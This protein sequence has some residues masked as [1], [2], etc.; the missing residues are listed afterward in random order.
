VSPREVDSTAGTA[1]Y[2]VGEIDIPA[3]IDLFAPYRSQRDAQGYTLGQAL[4]PVDGRL[5]LTSTGYHNR[6]LDLLAESDGTEDDGDTAKRGEWTQRWSVLIR[7]DL[8]ATTTRAELAIAT[9]RAT[10]DL[11]GVLLTEP[12]RDVE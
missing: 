12:D 4:L 6:P 1:T 7:S 2:R 10:T 5:H 11:S 8:V 3:Q 9:L